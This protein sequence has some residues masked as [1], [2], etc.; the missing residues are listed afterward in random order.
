MKRKPIKQQNNR[1]QVTL[2]PSLRR[3]LEQARE[4]SGRSLS[5]EIE[6]LLRL[7]LIHPMG[8]GL[9]LLKMDAGLLAWLRAF[10][11]GPG[12]FGDVQQTAVYLMRSQLVYMMEKEPWYAGTVPHLP[13][14][15]RE[16]NMASPKYQAILKAARG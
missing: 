16:A 7:A 12:F 1:V 8:D 6:A 11:A 15:I 2:S 9:L 4:Q 14:P 13:S 5:A 10:V 3:R